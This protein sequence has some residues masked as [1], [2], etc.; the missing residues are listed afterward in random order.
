MDYSN[1]QHGNVHYSVLVWVILVITQVQAEPRMRVLYQGIMVLYSYVYTP[2]ISVN[3]TLY[4][5]K[6]RCAITYAFVLYHTFDAVPSFPSTVA[7]A[8]FAH[9]SSTVSRGL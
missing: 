5:Y 2:K 7:L 9:F 3:N 6:L 1:T 4:R 8:I